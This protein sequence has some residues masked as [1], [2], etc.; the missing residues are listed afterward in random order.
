LQ[1]TSQGF[2]DQMQQLKVQIIQDRAVMY[3]NLKKTYESQVSQYDYLQSVQDKNSADWLH[4]QMN[5]EAAYNQEISLQQQSIDYLQQQIKYNNDLT[6]AQK[7]TLSD[8]VLNR[9]KD[10]LSLEQKLY[11]TRNQMATEIVDTYKQ[12]LTDMKDAATKNI[13][14][15]INA[16]NKAADSSS[17]QKKLSDAQKSAQDIQNQINQLMLDDSY[18]AKKKISDLKTQLTSQ[19]DSIT[20]MIT[21]NNKQLQID[22]LNAQKDSIST[23]YDNMLNDQEKFTQMQKDI[24]N[25]N[26][27]N[28]MDS[29][30]SLS[31]QVQKNVNILGTSVV[32]TLI[33]AINRANN[34]MYLST[35]NTSVIGHIASLDSGGMLPSW[36]SGGKMLLAHEKEMVLNK[37]DTSNILKIVNVARDF[38]SNV[39]KLPDLNGMKTAIA[40]GGNNYYVN[41][42]V[43]KMTGNQNDVNTFVSKFVN[44]I[45]SK[46]GSI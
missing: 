22:N 13:D 38:F 37:T 15:M 23:Y 41:F 14:N 17:Y 19:Q 5:R 27:Q 2:V 16:I 29:L 3:D 43:D 33:D 26:N 42:N 4:T 36:G 10:L 12:A 9:Q 32:N 28:I 21:D 34:Y 46:G 39:V 44:G 1:D 30:T 45:K 18:A 7:Q 6:D 11:D 35:Q 25:V 8:D 24:L 31:T 20:Q 40:G